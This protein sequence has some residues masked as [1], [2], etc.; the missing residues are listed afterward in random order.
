MHEAYGPELCPQLERNQF[1]CSQR[2]LKAIDQQGVISRAASS[3]G[4]EDIKQFILAQVL[5]RV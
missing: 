2:V 4:F 1:A 3:S 5:E